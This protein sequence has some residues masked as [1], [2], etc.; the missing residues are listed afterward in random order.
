M[1]NLM[2]KVKVGK[3]QPINI[4]AP[5]NNALKAKADRIYQPKVGNMVVQDKFG[6]VVDAGFSATELQDTLENLQEQIGTLDNLTTTHKSNLVSA[7]NELDSDIGNLNNLTTT[8]KN[9]VV[10]AINEVDSDIS[11][12]NTT[13]GNKN[14][15]STTATN[16]VGA[17]NEVKGIA[18]SAANTAASAYHY[19]G[20]KATVSALPSSNNQIGDVWNV[21]SDLDGGNY[22]WTGSAWDKLGDTVD[23]TPYLT[24]TEAS[25]T[26]VTKTELDETGYLTKSDADSLYASSDLFNED[27]KNKVESQLGSIISV[28]T[29]GLTKAEIAE[30]EADAYA[31]S[32]DAEEARL[33]AMHLPVYIDGSKVKSNFYV[34]PS[35]SNSISVTNV[36][37]STDLVKLD[38]KS[39]E[40]QTNGEYESVMKTRNCHITYTDSK[41]IFR[42]YI[43]YKNNIS[44][45][46]KV[47][48]G[49]TI[50]GYLIPISGLNKGTYC[51]R[52]GTGNS[53]DS[54]Y[55]SS[56]NDASLVTTVTIDGNTG[57]FS[58]G[59]DENNITYTLTYSNGVPT[60]LAFRR[61]S[62]SQVAVIE[63][64]TNTNEF[65]DSINLFNIYY[66]VT[67]SNGKISTLTS[68]AVDEEN[69]IYGRSTKYPWKTLIFATTNL[70]E[71]YDINNKSVN[72][73][74]RTQD[75]N[76]AII[77]RGNDIDNNQNLT[78]N[79][80]AFSRTTGSISVLPWTKTGDT[81]KNIKYIGTDMSGTGYRM[82]ICKG[83]WTLTRFDFIYGL[84]L[85]NNSAI[86]FP[87]LIAISDGAELTTKGCNYVIRRRKVK[88]DTDY[89]TENTNA[90][91]DA[92]LLTCTDNSNYKVVSS[93][94][95]A[96][97]NAKYDIDDDS[98][99]AS[100]KYL[101]NEP[102][103]NAEKFIKFISGL[104]KKVSTEHYSNLYN[105]KGT[106]DID[107][108]KD[109]DGENST[110]SGIDVSNSGRTIQVVRFSNT[111][112]MILNNSGQVEFTVGTKKTS[113]NRSNYYTLVKGD[114]STYFT[115]IY[116]SGF[117]KAGTGLGQIYIK[118]LNEE[119]T[120]VIAPPTDINNNEK[121]NTLLYRNVFVGNAEGTD[122]NYYLVVDDGTNYNLYPF[123]IASGN[124][125]T[126]FTTAKV[127]VCDETFTNLGVFDLV[128]NEGTM[129]ANGEWISSITPTQIL[130]ANWSSVKSDYKLIDPNDS[131]SGRLRENKTF[132]IKYVSNSYA[133]VD[134]ATFFNCDGRNFILNTA[135]FAAGQY[136]DYFP[137]IING[138]PEA[139]TFAW[140]K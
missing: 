87:G 73:Y 129:G 125:T 128:I 90:S 17:I 100:I 86:K 19:K 51:L 31:A 36:D 94:N 38:I 113:L 69:G 25:D 2:K 18:D 104:R 98:V 72:L 65:P 7:V 138:T 14:N 61:Y 29:E 44:I 132:Y 70:A 124:S 15:L 117:R 133:F 62:S 22:A 13:I 26:Y 79:L 46:K 6:N 66:T 50:T 118:D 68:V 109:I 33:R 115:G 1:A 12:I 37:A 41:I 140:Y 40:L 127:S 8:A 45:T 52:K 20:T 64:D 5:N 92:R 131:N 136:P 96:N 134:K 71:S 114:F 97:I 130:K 27:W 135:S 84:G 55:E 47:K 56:A 58:L 48:S 24:K 81:Y 34:D 59:T 111:S 75:S 80:P 122:G 82:L 99:T 89:Y 126:G 4:S 42:R 76:G 106:V 74:V 112:L 53:F 139:A 43:G 119:E 108:S 23:L 121:S 101:T 105:Y 88:L 95:D 91:L 78:L 107:L 28:D 16:L 32:L 110:L 21:G 93:S 102:Y 120:G 137:G 10:S 54:L 63:K 35:C 123:L 83:Y 116:N 9:N 60:K 85:S 30:E 103:T 39:A 3:N 11:A 77:Y 67:Y 49:N 57:T